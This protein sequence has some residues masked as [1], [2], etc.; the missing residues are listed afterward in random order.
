MD[1]KQLEYM[2]AIADKGNI[3]KA[4]ESL[5]ITQSGLN[6]QL[7]KLERELGMQLFFRNKHYLRPTQAGEIYL[8]SAREILRIKRSTYAYLGDLKEQAVG[9]IAMGLTHEHG[10][11]LFTDIFTAFNER[12]PGITFSLTEAIVNT[13]QSLLQSGQIDL[14]VVMLR[15]QEQID[16]NYIPVLEEEMILGI[17]K[18]HPM[19][20]AGSML[21]QPLKEIDTLAHFREDK[22]SL[23]FAN[24]TMRK[25]IDPQFQMA[26][27]HPRLMIESAMNHALIQLVSRGLCCTILP[28]TRALSSRFSEDCIWFRLPGRPSWHIYIAHR[29]DM[30]MSKCHQYFIQLAKDYGKRMETRFV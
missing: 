14:G 28:Y 17:P 24:S 1:L 15:E 3:S 23:I 19:A 20:A 11:D 30:H 12:Y 9:E 18:G 13:Q 4:A 6:Q 2:V 22:F 7:M 26:G 21:G 27:F 29:R 16:L 25:L 10:I 8:N 5:Y